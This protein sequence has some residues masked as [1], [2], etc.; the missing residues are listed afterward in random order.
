MEMEYHYFKQENVM[1]KSLNVCLGFLLVL[2]LLNAGRINFDQNQAQTVNK[3]RI[4]HVHQRVVANP[5]IGN[6]QG[7]NLLNRETINVIYEED[8]E[9]GE[10]G[11]IHYDGTQPTA[12]WHLD[13][14]DTPD[15]TGLSWWMGDTVINGYL[16]GQYVVLDTDPI[17]VPPGGVLT[18]DLNYAVEDPA[19]AEDPYDGWDGCN[20]RL[21]T[22]GG[23]TWTVIEG[24]PA[25]NVSSL[26][27]F[28]QEHG[29]GPGVPG[30]GGSS[31]GWVSASFD[32][33]AYER[34][35]VNIRFAFASD[36]GYSTQDDPGLFGMIVDNIVLGGFS[37]DGVED[38]LT[39]GSMVPL[40]GDIWYLGEPGDAP[41]PTHAMIFQNDAG[42]YDPDMLDYLESPTISLPDEGEIAVDFM[43]KGSFSDP[44]AW[45][46]VDWWGWEVSPD[47]GIT[48]YYMSNPYGD[49]SGLNYVY[50]D[51]PDTWSS[52]VDAYTL[53]GRIDDYA[54]MDVKF[55]I[56]F[57][58][59]SDDPDG[60]G[61]MVDD[62]KVTQTTYLP[63]PQNLTGEVTIDNEVQLLWDDLGAPQDMTFYYGDINQIS[64]PYFIP[65]SGDL[66]EV[67]DTG[68]GWA[69]Q[70]TAEQEA[71][72]N[73]IY[74]ALSSGNDT[75]VGELV[76]ITVKVWN[77]AQQLLWASPVFTPDAMDSI[78]AYDVSEED[79]FVQGDFYV[80]WTANDTTQPY[81]L[82][83]FDNPYEA[84]YGY[85]GSGSLI[86]L[87]GSE[88]DGNYAVFADGVTSGGEDITYNVY[89]SLT[90]GS[91]YSMIG[92]ADTSTFLHT[93]PMLGA[94]N[95]YV[96]TAVHSQ[97]ES[98]YSDEISVYPISASWVE[99]AQDDGTSEVGVNIGSNG[100]QAVHYTATNSGEVVRLSWYQ[101]GDGGALY[102]KI[103]DDDGGVPGEELYSKLRSGGS[104]GWNSYD[105]DDSI[106][107]SGDF[108]IGVKELSTTLPIGM[109]TDSNTGESYFSTDGT[110]WELMSNLGYN[111][112]TML[113]A[114]V[115]E[116]LSTG[117]ESTLPSQFALMPAY[118]NPFNPSTTLRFDLPEAGIV[119]LQV[120]NIQGQRVDEIL[121]DHLAAGEY[122]FKW[123]ASHLSSGVYF[124][125]ATFGHMHQTQKILLVK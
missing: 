98:E 1:G 83:D 44:N 123:N 90:S 101:I 97:G 21:S 124:V 105:V 57:E 111:G 54:G 30:W 63:V 28:G 77:N 35:D 39:P 84:A 40:G 5:A 64:Y 24:T 118:P 102:L 74:Y 94:D 109:D 119:R 19:G 121:H 11:W 29:E 31:D 62:Y 106:H 32:L 55:R 10:N 125:K 95:F 2:S 60:T 42:S 122:S 81:P 26:Y 53:N 15:G 9:S 49:P 33:S 86:S 3:T 43:L 50:T 59:D 93:N 45:P 87:A 27:S 16:N 51:A 52:V 66:W 103:F 82:V 22:D 34:Q 36:P 48:W 69:M 41:S 4:T 72:L 14:F 7:T 100:Y 80:G 70:Y 115:E 38:G 92:S 116:N 113:R 120:F 56:Y 68:S 85:H 71:Q 6:H 110:T 20:I 89:H 107:V 37:N 46:D 47:N 99:Y 112:N 108:W 13:D 114:F 67:A 17:Q 91:G 75:Y 78:L 76:P 117:G 96:V 104:D 8:F 58:S 65:G 79:I 23:S 61:I 73:N 12:W 88:W 18:F 25:Y